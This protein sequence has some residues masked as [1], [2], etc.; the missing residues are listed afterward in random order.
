M[1][2]IEVQVNS[3][4]IERITSC[5]PL[6]AII[7]L[8][9]N[10]LDADST[11]VEVTF[12]RNELSGIESIRVSDNG[13]GLSITDAREAFKN[14][15]GSLKRHRLKTKNGRIQHGREG[16]GH[17]RAF[18]LGN[19][20]AWE[21][22][23]KEENFIKSYKISGNI[24]NLKKFNIGDLSVNKSISGTKVYITEIVSSLLNLEPEKAVQKI[25]EEFS[26]YI[27]QYSDVSIRYDGHAINSGEFEEY[28]AEYP[29]VA[30]IQNNTEVNVDLTII[31]WRISTD[32][33]L[34]LC[35]KDGFALHK[36]KA[37]IRAPGF[38]FTIYLKSDL[39]RDLSNNGLLQIDELSSDL[40]IIL[41][42]AKDKMR[43]HFRMRAA[44][45]S[46]DL[47]QQW[48]EDDIYP[49]KG[50]PETLL[51][52]AERQIFDV[53]ALNVHEYLPDF[54]KTSDKNK[55]L[56]FFLLRSAIET[57]PESVQAIIRDVLQLPADKQEE[58]ARLLEKTSLEAMVN[59]SKVV[60]DRLDFLQG[61]ELLTI[62]FEGRKKTLECRQLHKIIAEHT[63]IFGEE[64]NLTV[65]DQ[66]LTNVLRRHLDLTNREILDNSPVIREDSSQGII[67]LML[68]KAIPQKRPDEKY[69]LVVE[70]KRPKVSIGNEEMIQVDEYAVAIA[71]DERFRDT[72]TKWEFW[73]IST[74]VSPSVR[75]KATQKD[76]PIGLLFDYPEYKM[77]VWVKTWGQIIEDCNARLRFFQE[78]LNYVSTQTSGIEYLRQ[79][80]KK[81]L[82]EHLI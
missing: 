35:D 37:G 31:E 82:P 27:R 43:E 79:V 5:N 60:S 10:S 30:N 76:R 52:E 64:F 16:K 18:R 65:S 68:S 72:N 75:L 58:F 51:E 11:I 3:D 46:V 28:V 12:S 25:T 62:D 67:D 7:E 21:T 57:S 42:T 70:L 47:V 55:K 48:K 53:V 4:H 56:Q 59:V 40:K 15:G 66:S 73:V 54:E 2:S 61:L 19:Q 20:V 24:L 69:H 1:E 45:Q 39:I 34:Y 14:L 26:F 23:F 41:D 36:I 33:A 6:A 81:Y 77:R 17:F 50:E 80:H 71:M 13:H 29:I 9:W 49:Y 8:I 38:N 22:S 44:S 78:K 74:E 32:R 63:W